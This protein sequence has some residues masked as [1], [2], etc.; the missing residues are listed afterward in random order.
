MFF[1]RLDRGRGPVLLACMMLTGES[2]AEVGTSCRFR[3]SFRAN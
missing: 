1:V 3:H 2:V